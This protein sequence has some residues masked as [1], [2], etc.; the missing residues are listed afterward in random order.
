METKPSAVQSAIQ[1]TILHG[2]YMQ[3]KP[4]GK[5]G[6]NNKYKNKFLFAALSNACISPSHACVISQMQH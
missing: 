3:A 5:A 2:D 4:R 1:L 6:F